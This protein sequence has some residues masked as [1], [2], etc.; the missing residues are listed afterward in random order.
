MLIAHIHH[1]GEAA[2]ERAT[3]EDSIVE[4]KAGLEEGGCSTF[5]SAHGLAAALFAICRAAFLQPATKKSTRL[6]NFVTGC[7]YCMN[8]QSFTASLGW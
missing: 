8:I 7:R 2:Q 4:D 1:A 6:F 3:T 5:V